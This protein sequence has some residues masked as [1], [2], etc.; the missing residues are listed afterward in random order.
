MARYLRPAQTL[1]AVRFFV[2][3]EPR[4]STVTPV[5]CHIHTGA[6]RGPHAPG[7]L[8]PRDFMIGWAV[9][10]PDYG[11]WHTLRDGTWIVT[12]PSGRIE[13]WDHDKFTRTFQEVPDAVQP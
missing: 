3:A 9:W 12:F 4:P 10:R 5:L 2:A 1:E 6:V 13:L 7:D 8:V 11:G